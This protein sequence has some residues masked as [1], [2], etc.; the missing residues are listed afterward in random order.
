MM[1]RRCLVVALALLVAGGAQAMSAAERNALNAA[2]KWLAFVDDGRYADA[3]PRAA[4]SFKAK[5]NRQD[6]RDGARDLRKPYGRLVQRKP[7][8]I[9]FIGS[10][11]PASD[12]T[13]SVKAGA[14]VAIIFTT[15]FAGDKPANEEVTVEFEKDGIW[16][17]AGYF[18]R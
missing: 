4:A 18:I 17:V 3:W 11:S 9:A 5:V 12:G 1:L 7:E 10:Q 8:K 13:E 15:K 14:T 16:R 6:W 2:E